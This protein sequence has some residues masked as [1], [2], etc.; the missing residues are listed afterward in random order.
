MNFKLSLDKNGNKICKVSGDGFRAFSIQT[1]GNLSQT[2]RDGI[3]PQTYGEV[4]N[5]VK[6]FGTELQKSLFGF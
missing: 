6:Q 4:S 3:T 5:Y 1:L 2:H